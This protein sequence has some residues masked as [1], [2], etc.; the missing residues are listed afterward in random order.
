V[1]GQRVFR[2]GIAVFLLSLALAAVADA[3]QYQIIRADYGY[4]NQ[5]VDVTQRLRELDPY[6]PFVSHGEQHFRH[7]SF[8]WKRQ[9]LTHS[10]ARTKW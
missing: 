4:G 5:R 2:H 7:R 1:S 9:D 8:P 3:Q 10:R 6:E